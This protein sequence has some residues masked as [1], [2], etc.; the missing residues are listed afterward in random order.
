VVTV[1]VKEGQIAETARVVG[2][3]FFDRV[4]RVSP[5]VSGLVASAGFREGDRVKAGETLIRLNTDFVLNEIETVLATMAQVE[6]RLAK[7]EKD[8]GRYE[9]LFRQNAASEQQYDTM[10]LNREDLV[11]QKGILEQN[12]VLA[13]LKQ[14]KSV[15]AAPFDA[16]VLEKNVDAGTWVSPGSTLCTLGSL[17]DLCVRAPVSEGFLLFSKTGQ[18]VE[19]SIPAL[20]KSVEGT[21]RGVVPLADPQTK[22]VSVK[23]GVPWMPGAVEN[24]SALVELP[25]SEKKTLLLVPRDA[26]VTANGATMVY[27]VREGKAAPVPVRVP[28]QPC[29]GRASRRACPWWWTATTVCGRGRRSSSSTGPE[30]DPGG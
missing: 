12:L 28:M 14:Q 15:V 1:P 10:V 24:M 11:R 20:G 4:S 25:T 26:L 2:A 9:T 13:R 3:L 5:E 22:T 30:T 27:T 19:V 8:V 7:A 18:K 21:V 6:T 23:M 16:M 29:P 17:E